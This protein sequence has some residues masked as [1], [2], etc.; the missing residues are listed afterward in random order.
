MNSEN[1]TLTP[2]IYSNTSST[3]FYDVLMSV[4]VLAL[5]SKGSCDRRRVGACLTI[6]GVVVGWGVNHSPVDPQC[7]SVG[8]LMSG[9]HCVR[10]IHAEEVVLSLLEKE[11][12][13]FSTL[14]ISDSPCL[15]CCELIGS[16]N[17]K[18]VVYVREYRPSYAGFRLLQSLGVSLEQCAFPA[19]FLES[20]VSSPLPNLSPSVV[21][22]DSS[23]VNCDSS[24]VNCERE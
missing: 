5:S 24:V 23:V 9:G 10:T 7:D 16:Y 14:Y 8:H 13:G 4:G 19:D 22:C 3:S 6:D 2:Y 18:R 20:L 15:K 1:T 17:V 11:V 21:N 12:E